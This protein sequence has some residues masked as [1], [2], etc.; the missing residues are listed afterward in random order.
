MDLPP[1]L[2]EPPAWLGCEGQPI[3]GRLWP[4]CAGPPSVR[5]H[6]ASMRRVAGGR[7]RARHTPAWCALHVGLLSAM[8]NRHYN[9]K[10]SPSPRPSQTCWCGLVLLP[11]GTSWRPHSPKRRPVGPTLLPEHKLQVDGHMSSCAQTGVE[12][13]GDDARESRGRGGM[14]SW[15]P[16]WSEPLS[17]PLRTKTRLRSHQCL[18][19]L[20]HPVEQALTGSFLHPCT[21]IVLP[22]AVNTSSRMHSR[23][24]WGIWARLKNLCKIS[25]VIHS[26]RIWIRPN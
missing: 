26:T 10:S 11:L 20:W 15:S 8:A 1:R 14:E 17:A 4:S 19:V 24:A 2:P 9:F 13:V 12:P 6:R 7:R 21:R 3:L 22:S 25:W 18:N 16:D 5:R 23:I